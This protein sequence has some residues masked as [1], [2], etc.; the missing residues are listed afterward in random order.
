MKKLIVVLIV[1]A[2]MWNCGGSASKKQEQV[3]EEP[4]TE[5]AILTVDELLAS[6]EDYLEKEVTLI[7]VCTHVCQ[8]SGKKLVI[9]GGDEVVFVF[10]KDDET[11]D[12]DLEGEDLLVTGI[13][14]AFE[15]DDEGHQ[16]ESAINAKYK[17]DCV[18]YEILWDEEDDDE[19]YEEEVE[20]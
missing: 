12:N 14:A 17:I 10:A 18:S 19:E 8:R 4:A 13:F 16:C 11:F 5:V 7:G 15:E 2:L 20:E 1:S 6:V 9:E 3:V